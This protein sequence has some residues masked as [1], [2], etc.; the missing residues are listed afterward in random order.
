MEALPN[1]PDNP[2]IGCGPDNPA[3]LRLAFH[4][5]GDVVRSGFT[6]ADHHQGW[7]GTMHS[8]VLYLALVETMNWTVYGL[9]GRV[10]LAAETSALAYERRA[11]LGEHL[12]LTGRIVD[13]KG[14][15]ARAEAHAEGGDRVGRLE[16]VYAMP[17]RAAFLDRMGWDAVPKA[18]EGAL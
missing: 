16:R 9:T 13:P 5:D 3:G 15:R 6:V 4:L 1:H 8:A 18:L 2:C 14:P 7:P 11:T 10:G 12:E 17:D